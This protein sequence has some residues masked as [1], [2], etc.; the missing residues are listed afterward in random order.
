[1]EDYCPET[2]E[3][4][5]EGAADDPAVLVCVLDERHDGLHYDSIDN[6]CWK[7]GRA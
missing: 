1:M 6:I 4:T 2:A 3:V 7:A 5:V